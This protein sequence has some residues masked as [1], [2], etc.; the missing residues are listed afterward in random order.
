M[1]S[2]ANE[3][4]LAPDFVLRVNSRGDLG[5]LEREA[6]VAAQLPGEV[7][8]PG[9]LAHGS[10]G[11]IEW[12]L[13]R[14]V[15]GVDLSRAWPGL[16]WAERR[17]AVTELAEVLSVLHGV[18]ASG[19]P[20]DRD[21]APPHV[22]PLDRMLDQIA[23][24][25]ELAFMDR[26]LLAEAAAFVQ[27]AWEAFDA[28][29]RGLVHGDLHL[30]NVLCDGGRITALLD[31]EWSRRSWLE[32]D[33]EILLSFCAFPAWFVAEDYESR[34]QAADFA[35]VPNWLAVAYPQWFA[36]PRREERL[37]VLGISRHLGALVDDPPRRP[38]EA[39]DPKDRRNHLRALLA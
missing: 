36:H 6:F 37:A 10:D 21:L 23:R 31:L 20:E 25:A 2:N 18:E 30:E 27:G 7:R 1:R 12:L 17:R 38:V 32:V 13:V 14:R 34:M 11:E 19:L 8:Y 3:A 5:R 4:W 28:Q 33:L 26:G 35:P 39:A 29:G 9:I 15:S 24:V 16:S 22:L